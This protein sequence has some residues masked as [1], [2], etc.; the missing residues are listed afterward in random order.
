LL[1]G[2]NAYPDPAN[3]LDGCVDDTYLVSELLQENGFVA[4]NT[5]LLTD[6]RATRDAILDR[7]HWL[8]DDV[9]DESYRVLYY[10]GHGVQIPGYG[11]NQQVDHL[12]DGL[13]PVDFDWVKLNAITDRDLLDVYSQLPY[14]TRFIAVFD[15]CYA[16]GLIRSMHSRIRTLSVPPDIRHRIQQW[17]PATRSWEPRKLGP[18]TPGLD[19]AVRQGYSGTSGATYKL[20]RALPLRRMD[21][22]EYNKVRDLR[23][24]KGPFLP[25][26]LE[27]CRESQL[28]YEYT[29]G[30]RTNGAFT[31]ALVHEY[32]TA[33]RRRAVT[34]FVEL[35]RKVSSKIKKLGYEEEPQLIGPIDIIKGPIPRAMPLAHEA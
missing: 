29:N 13:V 23:G 12:E 25:V 19:A 5:R 16:G 26:V 7:L 31:Y 3:Q 32:R 27:A 21:D 30:S 2:I 34:S 6:E 4:E 35:T 17:N 15:C 9:A 22:E 18:L 1:I 8:L 20:G 14:N 24:H 11:V 28:S 10:S 33:G